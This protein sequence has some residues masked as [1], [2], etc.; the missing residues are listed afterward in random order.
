MDGEKRLINESKTKRKP[1]ETQEKRLIN[2]SKVAILHWKVCLDFKLLKNISCVPCALTPVLKMMNFVFKR[3]NFALKILN[4]AGP[5]WMY[6]MLLSRSF[7][8]IL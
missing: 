6:P 7:S 1:R 5:T 3:M 2:Q 8:Y 4:F